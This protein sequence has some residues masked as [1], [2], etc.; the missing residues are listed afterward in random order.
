MFLVQ[1]H[2]PTPSR[3]IGRGS[4]YDLIFNSLLLKYQDIIRDVSKYSLPLLNGVLAAK[5]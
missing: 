3:Y 5:G 4:G 1:T 2:P